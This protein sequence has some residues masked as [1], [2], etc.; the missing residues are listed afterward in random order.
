MI[1]TYN[2]K[3]AEVYCLQ[4]AVEASTKK[5][6]D[7]AW[8]IADQELLQRYNYKNGYLEGMPDKALSISGVELSFGVREEKRVCSRWVSA[9]LRFTT[10]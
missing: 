4:V 8:Y 3:P 9:R 7:A 10:A 1:R 2:E 5:E 6:G